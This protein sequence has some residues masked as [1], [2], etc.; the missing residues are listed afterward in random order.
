[1]THRI[2]HGLMAGVALVAAGLAVGY[3]GSSSAEPKPQGPI[4]TR[5]QRVGNQG[6]TRAPGTDKAVQPGGGRSTTSVSPN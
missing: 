6:D 5:I 1:M 3:G 2:R 4:D